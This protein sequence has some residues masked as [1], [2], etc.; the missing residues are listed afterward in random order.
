MDVFTIIRRVSVPLA[1]LLTA[2]A[3]NQVSTIHPGQTTLSFDHSP[4]GERPDIVDAAE[5][6]DLRENQEIAFLDFFHD[7]IRQK[8]PP[9]ERFYEYLLDVTMDF[10][11]HSDTHTA[12]QALVFVFKRMEQIFCLAKRDFCSSFSYYAAYRW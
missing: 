10:Y 11:F 8:T 2:C 5:L 3:E 7:P 4:F 1:L 12:A 6:F 9:Y